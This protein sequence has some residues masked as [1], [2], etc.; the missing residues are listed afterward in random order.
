MEGKAKNSLLDHQ[1]T[2]DKTKA[3]FAHLRSGDEW[4]VRD[5]VFIKF[6][7]R[8]GGLTVGYGLAGAAPGSNSS[9]ARCWA[10]AL[11]SRWC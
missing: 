4:I 11:T 10:I 1:A 6:L 9:S 2:D 7:N 3:L 5:D 8:H